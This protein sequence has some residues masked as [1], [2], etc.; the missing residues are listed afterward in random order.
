MGRKRGRPRKQ[1]VERHP[2]G[3]V[4][5]KAGPTLELLD[6]RR[7]AAGSGNERHEDAG[8]LIGCLYL[9]GLVTDAQ[10]DAAR[11]FQIVARTY[12]ALLLAPPQPGAVRLAGGGRVLRPDDPVAFARV[13]ARYEAGYEAVSACGHAVLRDTMDALCERPPRSLKRMVVGLDALAG[14]RPGRR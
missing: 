14:A 4:V 12:E 1:G 3:A 9:R 13:K 2:G 6:H 10:R 7:A 8:W 11:R 5:Q